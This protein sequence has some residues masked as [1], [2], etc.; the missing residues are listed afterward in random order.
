MILDDNSMRMLN[1]RHRRMGKL[2]YQTVTTNC[3]PQE[4]KP[5]SYGIAAH[6]FRD[7]T[8]GKLTHHP[9]KYRTAINILGVA[10]LRTFTP[11][12]D[13]KDVLRYRQV[14]QE[15][16]WNN[17]FQR[18]KLPVAKERSPLGSELPQSHQITT[19]LHDLSPN[20]KRKVATALRG[21]SGVVVPLL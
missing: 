1:R 3:S 19:Q 15:R 5:M 18:H 8:K 10:T 14:C 16:K 12:T 13:I 11:K 20:V 2:L 21:L 9:K 6:E 17:W 7:A 4:K